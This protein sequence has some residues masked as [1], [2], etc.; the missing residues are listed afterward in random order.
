MRAVSRWHQII[1]L[2]RLTSISWQMMLFHW[3]VAHLELDI[4]PQKARRMRHYRHHTSLAFVDIAGMSFL[5]EQMISFF[6][7]IAFSMV[8]S[9]DYAHNVKRNICILITR[10]C[11][12]IAPCTLN[13]HPRVSLGVSL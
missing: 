4:G 10:H 12:E 9:M 8:N 7:L 2:Y 3:L 1:H 11:L 5:V 6:A 13:R